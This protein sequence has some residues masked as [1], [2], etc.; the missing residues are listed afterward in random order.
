MSCVG[1]VRDAVSYAF[2]FY[3]YYYFLGKNARRPITDGALRKLA[4]SERGVK[5]AERAPRAQNGREGSTSVPGKVAQFDWTKT[6]C[7]GVGRR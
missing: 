2:F 1:H 3:C 4:A 6:K 7:P 5:S